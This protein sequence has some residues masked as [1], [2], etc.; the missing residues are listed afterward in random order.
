VVQKYLNQRKVPQLFVAT[1]ASKWGVP[2]ES[3]WTMGW[4][5]DYATEAAIY[6]TQIMA[7]RWPPTDPQWERAPD[8]IE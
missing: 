7:K 5:P 4:P 3:A 2:K 1:S 8:F 6:A